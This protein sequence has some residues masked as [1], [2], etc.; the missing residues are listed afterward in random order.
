M[1][2]DAIKKMKQGKARG[3]SGVIVE[4]TKAGVR[5]TVTAI[6][7]LVNQI[8]YEE[9]IPK[10]TSLLLTWKRPLTGCL[11]PSYEEFGN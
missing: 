11:V 1:V 5:E 6:P 10:S 3:P 8:I 2:T 9:N 4:M 7:E